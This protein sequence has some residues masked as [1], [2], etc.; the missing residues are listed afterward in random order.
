MGSAT[1]ANQGIPSS[2]IREYPGITCSMNLGVLRGNYGLKVPD[3]GALN[4]VGGLLSGGACDTVS[5]I[6]LN[7]DV[8]CHCACGTPRDK[9]EQLQCEA[10]DWKPDPARC[11]ACQGCGRGSGGEGCRQQAE[12]I[13]PPDQYDIECGDGGSV[14]SPIGCDCTCKK[15]GP[16]AL[17]AG[18]CS[19]QQIRPSDSRCGANNSA[20]CWL[21]DNPPNGPSSAA[22]TMHPDHCAD[23][24]WS[25]LGFSSAVECLDKCSTGLVRNVLAAIGGYDIKILAGDWNCALR[26]DCLVGPMI[27][28][29]LGEMAAAGLEP[30]ASATY[31]NPLCQ[32]DG[33][34]SNWCGCGGAAS[35]PLGLLMMNP[36]YDHPILVH[37]KHYNY[38]LYDNAIIEAHSQ[39][40]CPGVPATDPY[41]DSLGAG[42]DIFG[43]SPSYCQSSGSTSRGMLMYKRPNDCPEYYEKFGYPKVLA[44]DQAAV[45]ASAACGLIDSSQ[46]SINLKI[47]KAENSASAGCAGGCPAWDTPPPVLS[48]EP[49]DAL[50]LIVNEEESLVIT[51]I[52]SRER[53]PSVCQ[54]SWPPLCGWGPPP[55]PNC[56]GSWPPP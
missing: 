34:F 50:P 39:S 11:A 9:V 47:E 30:C 41:T 14:I 24:G 45:S 25:G 53:G 3:C 19:Y 2:T 7:S 55:P 23:G 54:T 22:C 42:C 13:C 26:G 38:T 4:A 28:P 31:I 5:I 29:F 1:A 44:C 15:K 27:C 32:L 20:G 37:G 46:T 56:S 36:N 49:D 21:C 8:Q 43:W 12:A 16:C 18:T 10:N 17:N 51:R 35:L 6:E 33:V 52:W 40:T 48:E